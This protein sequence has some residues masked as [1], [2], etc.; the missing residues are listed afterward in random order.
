MRTFHDLFSGLVAGGL[1]LLLVFGA[2]SLSLIEGASTSSLV[3]DN[4]TKPATLDLQ[5][6]STT[7]P[8]LPPTRIIP[9][10]PAAPT[11]CPP[12]ANWNAY[13]LSGSDTLSTLS[14][15]YQISIQDIKKYNCLISDNLLPGTIIY[16]PP[17]TPTA[18]QVLTQTNTATIFAAPMITRSSCGPPAGWVRY[19]VKPNDTLFG[20]G[21]AYG[22]GVNQLQDA[23][24]LEG[25][26][27]IYAGQS[28]YV[29]NVLPKY[30]PTRT[31]TPTP[32]QQP[33][34]EPPTPDLSATAVAQQGLTLTA[35][36]NNLATSQAQTAT[37]QSI[38]ATGQAQT[39]SAEALTQTSIAQTLTAQATPP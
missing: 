3:A 5:E 2:L 25:S 39:A 8:V 1:S 38:Q 27:L 21:L 33:T 20:I 10:L 12:P 17:L 15:I 9:T 34:S 6:T 24:C 16:L 18:T 36:V 26:T 31:S 28:L 4:T 29:P 37:A 11:T 13:T 35:E 14:E 32:T 23:N 19:I 30:T 7:T 22:V